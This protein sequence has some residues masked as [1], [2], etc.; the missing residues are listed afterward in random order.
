MPELYSEHE[1]FTG[2]GGD[3]VGCGIVKAGGGEGGLDDDFV[4]GINDFA[5]EGD[6]EADDDADGE[7]AS[8]DGSV[9]GLFFVSE[10]FCGVEEV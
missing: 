6:E 5:V 2:F 4:E 7:D 1:L 3:G 9:F 10:D 8:E